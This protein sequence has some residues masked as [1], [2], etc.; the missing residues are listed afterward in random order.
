MTHCHY[1]IQADCHY[2]NQKQAGD[3]IYKQGT[4]HQLSN[5]LLLEVGSRL[6]STATEVSN[7]EQDNLS[8]LTK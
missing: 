4:S 6:P 1:P 5:T 7:Q 8:Y 2:T 3:I